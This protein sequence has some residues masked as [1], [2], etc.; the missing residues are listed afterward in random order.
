MNHPREA[1][2]CSPKTP[3]MSPNARDRTPNPTV[4][5]VAGRKAS[6]SLSCLKAHLPPASTPMRSDGVV[7]GRSRNTANPLRLCG[8]STSPPRRSSITR[9]T[10][11][12]AGEI[13]LARKN[14]ALRSRGRRPNCATRGKPRL[15]R[16]LPRKDRLIEP[17]LC[18]LGTALG[19]H[20]GSTPRCPDLDEPFSCHYAHTSL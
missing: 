18:H 11:E 19:R 17:L 9:H 12:T 2:A 13:G 20:G 3:A 16:A 5:R 15:G 6:S 7:G 4:R 10:E 8:R 1:Y 14:R